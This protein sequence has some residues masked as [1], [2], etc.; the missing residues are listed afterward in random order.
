MSLFFNE[1]DSVFKH[2][3]GALN[4]KADALSQRSDLRPQEKEE[5]HNFQRLLDPNLVI[6]AIAQMDP[7][8]EQEI[9]QNSQHDSLMQQVGKKPGLQN[10]QGVLMFNGR[11]YLPSL[12]LRLRILRTR[13]DH[14]V[15]GHFGVTKTL[16]AVARDFWWPHM[17]SEI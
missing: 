13:L 3:P 4:T 1:F 5:A 17:A 8:L 11:I 16:E 14:N 2:K 7:S 15:A 9:R 12:D 6:A 10:E